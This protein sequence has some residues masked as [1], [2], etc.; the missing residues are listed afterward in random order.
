M[1]N[2]KKIFVFILASL[3]CLF[4]LTPVGAVSWTFTDNVHIQGN[5]TV[6]QEISAGSEGKRM[7]VVPNTADPA[8]GDLRAGAIWVTDNSV[9]ARSNDNTMTFIVG[10]L[11]KTMGFIVPFA[12]APY[13]LLLFKATR[14]FTIMRVDCTT[15]TDNVVGVL[16][17]CTSANK[18]SCSAVDITDWT[19]TND[20]GGFF[21]SSGFENAGIAAGAWLK[22]TTTSLVGTSGDT[23]LTCTIQARE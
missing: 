8:P 19:I 9:K 12:S 17:E 15:S 13:D 23:I 10:S 18:T 22:W 4:V 21:V 3:F 14:A 11:A 7:T 2:A 20:V 16:Q 6:D 1:R 5:L